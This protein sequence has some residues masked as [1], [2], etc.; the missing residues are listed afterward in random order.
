MKKIAAA[1]AIAASCVSAQAAFVAWSVTGTTEDW[2]GDKTTFT[3]WIGID[4]QQLV[5][6]GPGTLG[7]SDLDS[8]TA[9]FKWNAPGLGGCQGQGIAT[10]ETYD[11]YLMLSGVDPSND[12]L[13]IVKI[14]GTGI[15]Q[16]GPFATVYDDWDR[17]YA[18]T[19]LTNGFGAD[20][21]GSS[22]LP[23]FSSVSVTAVSQSVPEPSPVTL[24]GAGLAGL[25]WVRRRKDTREQL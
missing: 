8:K 11:N 23:F 17:Y 15:G 7:W 10:M 16:P 22:S 19:T 3:A 14:G 24:I 4:T 25:L 5:L 21:Y 1:V 13:L 18:V 6:T 2:N 20:V 9:R 12:C